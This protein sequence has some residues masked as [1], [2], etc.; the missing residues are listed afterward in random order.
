MTWRLEDSE[1]LHARLA[2]CGGKGG[3][4]LRLV[5]WGMPVPPFLVLPADAAAAW[6]QPLRGRIDA[7]LAATD[8][9]DPAQCQ[10]AAMEISGW[11]LAHPV[12]AAMAADTLA[13]CRALF[14]AGY[15]CAVRSSA[16]AEDGGKD[17]FAGQLDTYLHVGEADLLERMRACI[18]S[19]FGART[20]HYRHHRG[21]AAGDE[22]IA[23]VVQQMVPAARAG[24]VFSM[25]AG[26]NLNEIVVA[27]AYGLGEGVVADRADSD[28][29]F[30]APRQPSHPSRRGGEG[31]PAG[32]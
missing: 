15:R 12:D 17:S 6:L 28:H 1:E 26:G 10:D 14:G 25:N 22:G 19:L 2:E 23:V 13:R 4:L 27:A 29:Y 9:D 31:H 30:I 7:R 8:R 5:D 3:S 11:I 16:I 32:A 18:A 21:L 20:L 24:V